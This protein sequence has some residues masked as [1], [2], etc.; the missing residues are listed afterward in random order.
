MTKARRKHDIKIGELHETVILHQR[1]LDK[2]SLDINLMADALND[3]TSVM[4]SY[5]EGSGKQQ[6]AI[7]NQITD[8]NGTY[9]KHLEDEA[10]SYKLAQIT[11]NKM[12]ERLDGMEASVT[13]IVN[14]VVILSESSVS[15]SK[16]LEDV[17]EIVTPIQEKEMI[18]V[19]WWKGTVFLSKL[20]GIVVSI[21][22]GSFTI[23]SFI[24]WLTTYKAH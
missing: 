3:N 19:G 12:G 24:Q 8:L 10:E 20:F 4:R 6:S 22:V 16:S 18:A 21:G 1:A 5:M 17:K 7:Q 15:M 13:K 14:S 23:Y 9:G 2:H 11:R